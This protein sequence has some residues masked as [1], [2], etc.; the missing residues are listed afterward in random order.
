MQ[1]KGPSQQPDQQVSKEVV[2]ASVR[3]WTWEDL[4]AL[5]L[6]MTPNQR[7]QPAYAQVALKMP[8]AKL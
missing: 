3:G 8:E 5:L 2:F 1:A 4:E 6:G 7:L